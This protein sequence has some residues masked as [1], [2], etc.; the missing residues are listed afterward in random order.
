MRRLTNLLDYQQI[1]YEKI[2]K[3]K[4]GALFM[5]M[6]TGKTRTII[7]VLNS[8]IENNKIKKILYILPLSTIE[9]TKKQFLEHCP[10]MLDCVKFYGIE[11]IAMSDKIY[12]EV[13]KYVDSFTAVVID[14]STTIKNFRSKSA[15]RCIK[16]GEKVKYRYILTGN[17]IPNTV[18]DLFSQLYFL[19]PSILEYYSW[20]DFA[21]K[22]VIY[23]KYN[24]HKI[25]KTIRETYIADKMQPYVFQIKKSEC[26]KLPSKNFSSRTCYSSED[27]NNI[28]ENIKNEYFNKFM[29]DISNIDFCA[30]LM[31]LLQYSA[32]LSNRINV[33]NNIL[34]EIDLNENKIIIFCKHIKIQ[35][36]LY[37]F[38]SQNYSV[39]L[40]NGNTQNRDEVIEEYKNKGQ[41]LILSYNIGSYGLNLQYANYIIY[42]ENIFDY[43]LLEQ[44]ENRIHRIGQNKSCHYISIYSD[45]KIEDLVFKNINSKINTIQMFNEEVKKISKLDNDDKRN[46]L[47][48]LF[49]EV[50]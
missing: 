1:A 45:L 7:E 10:E 48:K 37:K 22:H 11:S 20:Y 35:E 2:K 46:Y 30:M 33:L 31:K 6:G 36:K 15:K 38:L 29:N 14:E 44:S 34:D 3:N 32:T 23:S 16:I 41:I 42:Y 21:K 19:S 8:K 25:E 47:K 39:Y 43:N 17:S 49:K 26:I 50:I 28:Y 13:L 9:N 40:I 24:P 5:E 27:E 18:A 4:V 12:L